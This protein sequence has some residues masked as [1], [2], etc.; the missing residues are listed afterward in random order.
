MYVYMKYL[1]LK[2]WKQLQQIQLLL[3]Q[4]LFNYQLTQ[5]LY[6]RN[7][8]KPLVS[9]NP[10]KFSRFWSGIGPVRWSIGP[11]RKILTVKKPNHQFKEPTIAP[12]DN[13][14]SVYNRRISSEQIELPDGRL[15]TRVPAR[16]W[17]KVKI[18]LVTP[19][20]QCL[21]FILR[22]YLTNTFLKVNVSGKYIP[23]SL[24]ID[25]I[26]WAMRNSWIN[27]IINTHVH[28]FQG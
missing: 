6:Q 27:N 28:R 24:E 22:W 16:K 12:G 23:N 11:R 2:L 26:W 14:P 5:A 17:S 9:I 25:N 10:G 21:L 15:C 1:I 3:Q 13:R 7:Q 8:K 18:I 20:D 4:Q 19:I